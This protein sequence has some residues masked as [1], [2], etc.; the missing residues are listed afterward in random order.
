MLAQA[1]E[2]AGVLGEALHQDLAGTVQRG[3]GVGDA[4]VG[5]DKGGS[6]DLR[7][8]SWVGEQ[9]QGQRFQPGLPGDQCL[10]A[11]L[12]FVGQVEVLEALLAFRRLDIALQFR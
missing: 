4:L 1:L 2:Q 9:G 10:A 12:G 3:L 8:P 11:A 7:R 5:I 6:L